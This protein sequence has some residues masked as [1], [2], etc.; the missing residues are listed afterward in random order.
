M[1]DTMNPQF[2][3]LQL[4]N[5]PAAEAAQLV[6]SADPDANQT[7]PIQ[8]R[9]DPTV[10]IEITVEGDFIPGPIRRQ[11]GRCSQSFGD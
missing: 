7:K 6:T 11:K 8:L 5:N 2:D 9:C 3:L 4:V 10:C 1:S